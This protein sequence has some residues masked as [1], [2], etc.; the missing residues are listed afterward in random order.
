VLLDH[1]PDEGF[2]QAVS[3]AQHVS[4]AFRGCLVFGNCPF[5]NSTFCELN[6]SMQHQLIS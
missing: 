2:R 6:R 1:R 5:L 3:D 4:T